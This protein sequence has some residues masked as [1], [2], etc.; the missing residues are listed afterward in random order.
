[1]Q[2][3]TGWRLDADSFYDPLDNL[4]KLHKV[5]IQQ[6]GRVQ[7]SQYQVHLVQNGR[8]KEVDLE[9]NHLEAEVNLRRFLD[10]LAQ[11]CMFSEGSPTITAVTIRMDE[12]KQPQ[13]IF[14][15]NRRGGHAERTD[16]QCYIR[17]VISRFA[18]FTY[19]SPMEQREK[20][21][22]VLHY[23]LRKNWRRVGWYAQRL[24]DRLKN[25]QSRNLDE[26]C[27]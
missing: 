15:S 17:D 10:Y 24:S 1:M 12:E 13:Y 2:S 8:V 16:M 26:S 23:V 18:D 3:F 14:V 22:E 9:M 19:L 6:F 27:E 5:D 21:K 7:R 20:C 11:I 4:V 25:L